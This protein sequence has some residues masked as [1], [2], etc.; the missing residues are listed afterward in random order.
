MKLRKELSSDSNYRTLSCALCA[1]VLIFDP[2][3]TLGQ[4]D[5]PSSGYDVEVTQSIAAD[6]ETFDLAIRNAEAH[7]LFCERISIKAVRAK[8]FAGNCGFDQETI[9]IVFRDVVIEPS[10]YFRRNAEGAASGR[11]YCQIQGPLYTNC[12]NSCQPN[13]SLVDGRCHKYCTWNGRNFAFGQRLR[14][15]LGPCDIEVRTCSNAGEW[16][17]QYFFARPPDVESCDPVLDDF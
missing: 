3:T 11:Y 13:H 7:P 15:E 8:D 1:T 12:R 2:S 16:D 6:K 14:F 9:D 10:N 4:V 17:V 5:S